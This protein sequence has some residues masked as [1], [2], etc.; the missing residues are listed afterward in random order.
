MIGKAMFAMS[1]CLASFFFSPASMASSAE[2]V[3]LSLYDE[4]PLLQGAIY[5]TGYL[6]EGTFVSVNFALEASQ[7]VQV[8]MDATADLTWPQ[9]LT[10]AWQGVPGSG[11]LVSRGELA[12]V[13]YLKLDLLGYEGEWQVDSRQLE[14]TSEL[15][16][17]P[18]LL[19][20]AD[21]D[22]VYLDSYGEGTQMFQVQYVP[23]SGVTIALNVDLS[24]F[25]E[26]TLAGAYVEHDN[27]TFME[28]EGQTVLMDVPGDGLLQVQSEYVADWDSRMDLLITPTIQVCIDIIGC[29]DVAS[30]DIPIE[31]DSAAFLDPFE[32]VEYSFSL[33]VI[34][35]P[36]L[37]HDFGALEW[38][39]LKP[40]MSLSQTWGPPSSRALPEYLDPPISM[41][42][43]T[44]SW[45]IRTA[46]MASW[47]PLHPRR[48]GVLWAR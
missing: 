44:R 27:G 24:I 48:W 22:A 40:G 10:L 25:L 23:F 39:W 2:P 28:S 34:E 41:S 32:P 11:W 7:D 20:G 36:E 35:T 15:G 14:V 45:R 6:P 18:L 12:A 17:D 29:Y 13:T 19:D 42:I 16:F 37:S 8:G 30:F 26:T 33:P 47:S 43:P 4:V 5:E 46:M 31:M 1:A 9:A 21:P 3:D 38:A